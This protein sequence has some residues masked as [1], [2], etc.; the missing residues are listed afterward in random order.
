MK[1]VC[2][3]PSSKNAFTHQIWNSYL[4]EHSRYAPDS[5]QI[6]KT[7]SEVKVV[8]TVNQGWYAILCHPMM[9]ADAKFG[10]PTSNDMR[11]MLL[12]WVFYK[13]GQRSR[14]GSQSPKNGMRHSAIPRCTHTPNV[15][16]LSQRIQD[17]CSVHDYSKNLVRC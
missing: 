3:T 16:F 9:H 4:T 15:G 17:I 6:L 2:D 14:S 8:V 7:S 12:I 10:I 13:L 1:M 11:D 5:M